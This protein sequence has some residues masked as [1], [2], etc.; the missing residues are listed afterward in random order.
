MEESRLMKKFAG[1]SPAAKRDVFA[2]ALDI[3]VQE[4]DTILNKVTKRLMKE[5]EILHYFDSKKK[6]DMELAKEIDKIKMRQVG[7]RQRIGK[8]ESAIRMRSEEIRKLREAGAT[9]PEVAEYL[10]KTY[11]IVA[12]WV[13]IRNINAAEE[14]GND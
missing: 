10:R 8:K 3:S 2:M 14:A 6:I 9:W 11:K 1:F 5:E 4:A 13:W 7:K 12:S